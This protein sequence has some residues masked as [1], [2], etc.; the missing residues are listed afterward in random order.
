MSPTEL[1]DVVILIT[2]S[3]DNPGKGHYHSLL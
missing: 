1:L 2:D 3:E